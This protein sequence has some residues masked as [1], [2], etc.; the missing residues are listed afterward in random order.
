MERRELAV[1][2]RRRQHDLGSHKIARAAAREDLALDARDL[3]RERGLEPA[4]AA[5]PQ[6]RLAHRLDRAV[7]GRRDR[8]G[9]RGRERQHL[10]ARHRAA[11][12]DIEAGRRVEAEPA[13]A[14]A[15]QEVLA[16]GS[17]LKELVRQRVAGAGSRL[18][19]AA[20]EA[21]QL[22]RQAD[23]IRGRPRPRPGRQPAASPAGPAGPLRACAPGAGRRSGRRPGRPAGRGSGAGLRSA[24]RRPSGARAPAPRH[25]GSRARRRWARPERRDGGR[26]APPGRRETA[27]RGSSSTAKPVPAQ[28][29]RSS[30]RRQ[31]R[32]IASRR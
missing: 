19:R 9:G 22:G 16:R 15:D 14:A 1:G 6:Q 20:V 8:R 4:G 21:L 27:A 18:D 12:V 13:A 11:A 10:G 24:L 26:C 5:G 29:G 17:Q 2:A 31:V 25:G 32:R 23:A 30:G 7:G 28:S 3:R